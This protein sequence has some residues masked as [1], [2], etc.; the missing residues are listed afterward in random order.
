MTRVTRASINLTALRHNLSIAQQAAPH[1]KHM[2]VIKANAYGHGMLPVA[3][4]LEQA[5]ALAVACIDE[6]VQL[7]EAGITKPLTILEGFLD[8]QELALCR[9]Y[10]LMPVVH[11]LEQIAML[12][13][14]R[15]EPLAVWLKIDSGMHRLGIHTD[16]ASQAWRRLHECR[17]IDANNIGLMSHLANADDRTDVMTEHQYQLFNRIRQQLSSSIEVPITSL[18]N[19]AGILGWTQTHLDWVRP[20]IMLYGASPFQHQTGIEHHLQPVMTLKSQL[21]AINFHKRDEHV[22]Y[23][24]SWRCPEDMPVGVIAIGYGDGYPRHAGMGTPIMINGQRAALIGR[25]SMDMLTVDLRGLHNINIGDEVVLWGEG[26]PVEEV[27]SHAG[28]IAYDLLC[29]VN[30]RVAVQ[31]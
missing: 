27:A 3:K 15:A 17:S 25:V 10:Q 23:G 1:S 21:I 5:D 16:Q 6:A 22:G 4:A 8:P 26:L 28:T 19:S 12:E 31:Y 2:A 7:R 9:R 29:G 14:E 13:V 18:A 20:G 30:P 11:Q 24:G